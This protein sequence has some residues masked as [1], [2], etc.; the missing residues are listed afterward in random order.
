[1][2]S[3]I[4]DRIRASYRKLREGLIE[5]VVDEYVKTGF[6][7]EVYDGATGKGHDNHP[8]TGWTALI[9]NIMSEMF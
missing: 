2:P 3:Q 8:F 4:R 6:L 5:L 7:W 1:M 9:V